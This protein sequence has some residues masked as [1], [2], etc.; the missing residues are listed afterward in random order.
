MLW[1]CI[2][3]LFFMQ[4][5]QHSQQQNVKYRYI[6]IFPKD[7]LPNAVKLGAKDFTTKLSPH[8][9]SVDIYA[10]CVA[11]NTECLVVRRQ[12]NI[13]NI[14]FSG[15]GAI[16]SVQIVPKDDSLQLVVFTQRIPIG[17]IEKTPVLS[18]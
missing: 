3:I 5:K 8:R 2:I 4:T 12:L 1:F 16:D 6:R 7:V 9:T 11:E 18:R 14:L 10:S 17:V 13:G 15:E